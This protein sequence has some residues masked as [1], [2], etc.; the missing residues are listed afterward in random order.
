[1]KARA[2]MWWLW[3]ATAATCFAAVLLPRNASIPNARLLLIVAAQI[4]PVFLAVRFRSNRASFILAMNHGLSA[5]LIG[6]G[7]GIG[8]IG[9]LTHRP[10]LYAL[11]GKW[12]LFGL[13]ALGGFVYFLRKFEEVENQDAVLA[14]EEEE[15]RA[16]LEAAKADPEAA[17]ALYRESLDR[18]KGNVDDVKKMRLIPTWILWACLGLGIVGL[19][20]SGALVLLK[21]GDKDVLDSALTLGASCFVLMGGAVSVLCSLKTL[22][23]IDK[24]NRDVVEAHRSIERPNPNPALPEDRPV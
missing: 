3:G 8:L 11:C 5:T 19:L 16:K 14:R 22:R 12:S 9:Y 17:V 23:L 7:S 2:V 1:M 18:I 10:Q 15:Y 13:V 24:I 20:S 4:L 21:P 6:G